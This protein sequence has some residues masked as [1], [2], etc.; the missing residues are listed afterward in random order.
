M[1]KPV[2]LCILDGFGTKRGGK[3]DAITAAST[4]N[5][6]RYFST[7]PHSELETYG[8]AVGLPEG[9][10]GN[11]EVGHMN[12]GGGRIV[13]QQL[14][15][16]DKSFADKE[17]EK[18]EVIKNSITNLKKNNGNAHILGL[19]S[20]GGVHAHIDHIINTAK[21]YAAAGIN[22]YIHV[23]TDGRDTPPA[24]SIGYVEK[25]INE[26]KNIKN[27]HIATLSGRYYAMDRDKRWERVEKA[28]NSIA[29][30]KAEK[31]FANIIDAIKQNHSSEIFDEF[32]VPQASA[33]Y[34][35]IKDGDAII[36]TNF[37]A[38]RAR[39][40]LEALT[41]SD[42]NGFE[43]KESFKFSSLIGFSHYSDKLSEN[44]S[45]AFPTENL[46]NTLGEVLAD[47]GL[48][49]LRCAETEK[50]AHVTFFFSGGV[51]N[52]FKGEERILV[53]SPDVATYDLKPE[54]SAEEVTDKLVDAIKNDRFDFIAVNYANGDMVGH[55]GVF[56][57]AVKAVETLDR[58]ME[59]LEQIIKE[60]NGVMLITADHGN[61]EEMLDENGEPH[62]Q[63]TVGN[64]PFILVNSKYKNVKNGRLCDIAPT[65]LDIMG[66]KKPSE[67]N[68][69]SLV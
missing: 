16:I 10:M 28:Y 12:I 6:D 19:C 46:K 51:E 17:F 13:F 30:G 22:T 35:G 36:M 61:V 29:L 58:C 56:S 42:F 54:M 47:N 41:F 69:V 7:C 31:K 43:H 50:Y 4:P 65:I 66:I 25:L 11:S 24:S 37:R 40:I 45:T 60:K 2:L 3:Y 39:Q 63:H 5:F 64:V 52:N 62:T 27:I 33:D 18:L 55:T 44:F 68:G 9:Q 14:P 1:T 20:D 53:K 57:A 15:R 67:M 8:L 32:I 23:F 34:K 59:R 48:T 26:T 49:Q 38:D 21:I